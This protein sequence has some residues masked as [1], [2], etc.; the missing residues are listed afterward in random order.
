VRRAAAA[1]GSNLIARVGAAAA[2]MGKQHQLQ[3]GGRSNSVG[4]SGG[5]RARRE[6]SSSADGRSS[7]V[8]GKGSQLQQQLLAID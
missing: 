6:K 8:D 4:D 5:D 2:E 7:S 3:R 1:A